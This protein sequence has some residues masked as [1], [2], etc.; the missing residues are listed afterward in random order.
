MCDPLVTQTG[1]PRTHATVNVM[2]SVQRKCAYSA[3]NECLQCS[4]T[5]TRP[6]SGNVVSRQTLPPGHELILSSTAPAMVQASAA[7]AR[8]KTEVGV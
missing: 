8:I 5:G 3:P 2:S 1:Y 7:A 4:I 6:V